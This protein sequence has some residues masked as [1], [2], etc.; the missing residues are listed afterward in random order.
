MVIKALGQEPVL[1]LVAGVPGLKLS[2][3]AI[4]VDRRELIDQ[5]PR[6]VCRR[7]LLAQGR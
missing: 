4:V 3:G 5:H 7:R 1:E 6:P 2:K